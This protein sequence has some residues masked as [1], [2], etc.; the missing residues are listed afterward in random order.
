M[1]IRKARQLKNYNMPLTFYLVDFSNYN[2][3]SKKK[4]IITRVKW[5]YIKFN[6][7]L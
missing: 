5:G 1:T 3:D 4:Y 2:C 7:R 6:F